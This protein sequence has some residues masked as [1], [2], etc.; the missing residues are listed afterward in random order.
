MCHWLPEREA[1]ADAKLMQEIHKAKLTYISSLLPISTHMDSQRAAAWI[2]TGSHTTLMLKVW[3]W[4]GARQN[5]AYKGF[6][7][8]LYSLVESAAGTES[9]LLLEDIPSTSSTLGS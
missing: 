1:V 3:D 8:R 9:T 6:F 2:A 4:N 7:C 5:S